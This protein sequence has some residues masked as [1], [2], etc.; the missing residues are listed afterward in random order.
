MI[1]ELKKSRLLLQPN[2]ASSAYQDLTV[3]VRKI[4][5]TFH[6]FQLWSTALMRLLQ[7]LDIFTENCINRTFRLEQLKPQNLKEFPWRND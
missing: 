4:W 7:I 6:I 3:P 1:Q 2:S 5:L